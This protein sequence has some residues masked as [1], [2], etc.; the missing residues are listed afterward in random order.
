MPTGQERDDHEPPAATARLG[1]RYHHL[2]V[3]TDTPR[4][5]E[6][7][8][9]HLKMFVSGFQSSAFG[10]EWMRFEPGS[11]VSELVRT[12]PHLAF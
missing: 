2:G 6:R 1:W 12:V 5:G 3:P 8:L 7:Y 10:A 4:P 9:P 11:T